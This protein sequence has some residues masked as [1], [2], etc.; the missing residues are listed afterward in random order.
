MYDIHYFI[1]NGDNI[2][3][4]RT[5]KNLS[6]YYITAEDWQN[7]ETEPIRLVEV[8]QEVVRV[9]IRYCLIKD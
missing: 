5:W 2:C 3:F 6:D 4:D 9:D 1:A 7:G 8:S